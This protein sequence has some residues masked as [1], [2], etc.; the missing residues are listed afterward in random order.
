[1]QLALGILLYEQSQR[2]DTYRIQYGGRG[3]HG[4]EEKCQIESFNNGRP[5][6]VTFEVLEPLKGPT[7]LYYELHNFY[8]V[9]Q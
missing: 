2:I 8:A 7:F 9:C 4:Q 5:C 1:M 3:T 6:N